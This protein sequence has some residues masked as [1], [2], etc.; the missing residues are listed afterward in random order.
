MTH[1]GGFWGP[2]WEAK[3]SQNRTKKGIEKTME[4]RKATRWPKNRNKT[5]QPRAAERVL[6]PGEVYPFKQGKPIQAAGP[7]ARKP[8][9]HAFH[10][11]HASPHHASPRHAT[12]RLAMTPC[13]ATPGQSGRSWADFGGQLGI[14]NPT[15]SM[16]NRCQDALRL[17]LRYF[18]DSSWIF[19]GFWVDFWKQNRD[20]LASKSG[21]KSILPL[22]R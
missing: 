14:K 2:S 20:I 21:P 18:I 5:L 16:K 9:F 19:D 4:K 1:F 15:K 17:G 8:T 11:F 7:C 3:W 12:P 22:N 10:A 13:H 6:G